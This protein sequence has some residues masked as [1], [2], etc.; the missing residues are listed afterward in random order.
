MNFVKSLISVIVP[1]SLFQKLIPHRK[2][3]LACWLQFECGLKNYLELPL[4]E[5]RVSGIKYTVNF[6]QF[7]DREKNGEFMGFDW[8]LIGI[9][10]TGKMLPKPI[11]GLKKPIISPKMG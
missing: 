10:Q 5:V 9:S 4:L 3:L 2:K 1:G 8:Y 6:V 11:S 7:P